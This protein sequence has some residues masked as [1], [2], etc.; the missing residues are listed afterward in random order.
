M[1]PSTQLSLLFT[2]SL[3]FISHAGGLPVSSPASG[4][5]KLYPIVCKDIHENNGIRRCLKLLEAYPKI[6]SAKNILE[7]CRHVLEMAIDRSK[8]AQNYFIQEMKKNPSSKAI[9]DCATQRYSGT[10]G[11]FESALDEL[12]Q[13]PDTANYDVKVAG[14]G[15]VECNSILTAEKV[16]NPPLYRLNN[17]IDFISLVAFHATDHLRGSSN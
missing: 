7:L 4:S 8:E 16:V 11:S 5:T 6:T 14:D 3:I 2:L 1:N 12:T 10:V 9:K 17:V 13:S 15:P